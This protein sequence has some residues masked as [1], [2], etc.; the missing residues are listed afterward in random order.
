[1]KSESSNHAFDYAINNNTGTA[2]A[3][4]F[5][6]DYDSIRFHRQRVVSSPVSS[7]RADWGSDRIS[8][9]LLKARDFYFQK[10]PDWVKTRWIN[11]VPAI[12]SRKHD[13]SALTMNRLAIKYVLHPLA[14]EDALSPEIH[15]PKAELYAAHYFIMAPIFFIVWEPVPKEAI[16]VA[17][18]LGSRIHRWC[19][20]HRKASAAELPLEG[21]SRS[22]TKQISKVCTQTL[23]IFVLVPQNDTIITYMNNTVSNST[24][25]DENGVIDVS[26][27]LWDRVQN[28]LE[29]S[30]S[31]LRQYDAQYL[32]YALLDEAVD[33][34]DPIVEALRFEIEQQKVTLRLNNF[35][36]LARIRHLGS[37]L[38]LVGRRFK[39][40]LRLLTHVIEDDAISP[41]ATV[42]LRDVLDNLERSDEDLRQLILDCESIDSEANKFQSVKMDRTLYT[43]TVLSAVFLPA[44]FLTGVYGKVCVIEVF[45]PSH[46]DLV[47]VAMYVSKLIFGWVVVCT[48][49]V[50]PCRDELQVHARAR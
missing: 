37:Q 32:T 50:F 34:I 12:G 23:S 41:G 43:L 39:P 19:G 25:N 16:S 40:F 9:H 38:E 47:C 5:V 44:Q 21:N 28:E 15:R 30:C 29:K 3:S 4:L 10:R 31:K 22:R 2:D 45:S 26:G 18:S 17:K 42:Y 20:A 48:V 1:L 36:D 27:C 13:N 7:S 8:E 46:V 6:M 11:V 49:V 14:L 35:Q 33:L 24:K